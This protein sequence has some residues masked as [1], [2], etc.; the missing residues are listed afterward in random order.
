LRSDSTAAVLFDLGGVLVH[1]DYAAI[2]AEAASLGIALDAATLPRAEGHARRAIDARASAAGTATGNDASRV[3]DYFDDL[4]AGAGI[5]EPAR[6]ELVPRL[7]VRHRERNLW[8]VP[9]SC[10]RA[11]LERLREAGLR[12]GVVSNADGRAGSVLEAAGLA[13]SLDVIVDSHL[14]GVEKPDPEIFRRALARLGATADRTLFVG[15]IVSIDVVGAR[16]A[17]LRPVLLDA[18]GAYEDADCDRI[19]RPGDLL[20][21]LGLLGIDTTG[22]AA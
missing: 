17:G 9:F 22:G 21:L 1:L 7:R 13:S 20:G 5:A 15:D 19:A 4:L 14:E 11:T 6:S 8:R 10:A 3:P 2:A 18:A 12:V 16:G